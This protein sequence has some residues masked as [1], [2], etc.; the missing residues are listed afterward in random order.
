MQHEIRLLSVWRWRRYVSLMHGHAEMD[1][2]DCDVT[3]ALCQ[4]CDICSRDGRLAVNCQ[5]KLK[6]TLRP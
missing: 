1:L 6:T 5:R 3:Q 4:W 2:L